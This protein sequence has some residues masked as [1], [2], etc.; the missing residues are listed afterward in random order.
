MKKL[1]LV[2]LVFFL[3]TFTLIS[4]TRI[5]EP[6]KGAL[7]TVTLQNL[8]AIPIEYGSLISITSIPEGPGLAQLW[9]EDDDRNIRIVRVNFI[10][11]ITLCRDVTIITR[12]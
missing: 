2:L 12:Y 3:S 8:N 10:G 9:F 1:L 11:Q 6:A 7:K 5:Q 4:C